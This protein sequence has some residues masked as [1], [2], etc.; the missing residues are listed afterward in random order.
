MS[1]IKWKCKFTRHD[2]TKNDKLKTDPEFAGKKSA[3]FSETFG[4]STGRFLSFLSFPSAPKQYPQIHK[5]VG[6]SFKIND[7]L[8]I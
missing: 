3:R 5:N 4:R 1:V 7:I 2:H 8:H 6:L